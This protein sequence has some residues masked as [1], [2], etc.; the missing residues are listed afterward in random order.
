MRPVLTT[1]T[2]TTTPGPSKINLHNWPFDKFRQMCILAG[3]DYL[4]SVSGVGLTVAWRYL[5]D[6][7]DARRAIEAMRCNPSLTVPDEY[8]TEFIK[9]RAASHPLLLL[10]VSPTSIKMCA[11]TLLLGCAY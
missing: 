6:Y 5:R 1:T 8:A 9:V 2:T 11:L 4:P 3:C 7:G 10:L